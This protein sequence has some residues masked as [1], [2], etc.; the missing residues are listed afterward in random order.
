[1]EALTAVL[2]A[3]STI[4][5]FMALVVNLGWVVMSVRF[6]AIFKWVHFIINL[7]IHLICAACIFWVCAIYY[8]K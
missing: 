3:N 2:S 5:V 1:M 7:I 4:L 6:Y 8:T